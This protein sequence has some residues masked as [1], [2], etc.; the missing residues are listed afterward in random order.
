MAKCGVAEVT[1]E[2]RHEVSPSCP[3][4]LLPSIFPRIRVFS[5][6]LVLASRGQSIGA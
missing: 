2:R 3:L 1:L 5:N 4:L 6:E